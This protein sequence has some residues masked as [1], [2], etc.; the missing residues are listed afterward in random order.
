MRTG[1]AGLLALFLLTN[2]FPDNARAAD[3]RIE[4]F[5]LSAPDC[6]YCWHWEAR[7]RSTLL[8]SPEGKAIRFIE[9]RG[10]TLREPIDAKHYPPEHL[11][12]F[13][14]I[15]PS[16]GVPRFLLAIDGKLVANAYGTGGYNRTFLPA[17]KEAVARRQME[18]P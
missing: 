16:R 5:Y 9:I 11:W 17:L 10:D 3:S 4:V 14:Q 6:P 18:K 8:D 15:G 13:E 1:F 2:V 12:V 7:S